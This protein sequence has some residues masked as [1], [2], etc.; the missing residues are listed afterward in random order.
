MASEA[1]HSR[2]GLPSLPP[3]P[4]TSS[5]HSSPASLPTGPW[6]CTH[7]P[8]TLLSMF[9]LN[10]QQAVQGCVTLGKSWAL[11]AS[12]PFWSLRTLTREIPR[13]PRD[14]WLSHCMESPRLGQRW[15]PREG[16]SA[17]FPGLSL[18]PPGRWGSQPPHGG[19][20][21]QP[22]S[23][24]DTATLASQHESVLLPRRLQI[25]ISDSWVRRR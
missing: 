18:C 20:E 2:D 7:R 21:H 23:A 16:R 17:G 6:L 10:P 1:S 13:G 19:C 5:L 8:P 25:C 14:W 3:S 9:L 4:S 11:W 12:F 22:H 24:T 15:V